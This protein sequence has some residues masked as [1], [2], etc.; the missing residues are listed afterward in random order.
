MN[1]IN[2]SVNSSLLKNGSDGLKKLITNTLEYGL[3]NEFNDKEL[4]NYVESFFAKNTLMPQIFFHSD[5]YSSVNFV[6]DTIEENVLKKEHELV[7]LDSSNHKSARIKI[8]YVKKND[9]NDFV[10]KISTNTSC[11]LLE[12]VDKDLNQLEFDF[13]EK[14]YE[15]CGQ[16]NIKLIINETYFQMFSTESIFL[17]K[18][19]NIKPD[20]LI[21]SNSLSG[22]L[23]LSTTL[24]KENIETESKTNISNISLCFLTET[25]KQCKKVDF[26]ELNQLTMYFFNS[27]NEEKE[28]YKFIKNIR[29]FGRIFAIDIIDGEDAEALHSC[30]FENG[31]M[32]TLNQKNS[33]IVNIPIFATLQE[34]NKIAKCIKDAFFAFSRSK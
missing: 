24:A 27:I 28:N 3:E 5:K 14:I 22:N 7:C 13:V 31:I 16:N 26:S 11:V 20:F 34:V 15:I 19:Y 10:E 1:K 21:L 23:P 4:L 18:K 29:T 25:I 32:T 8:K 30:F 6:I 2:C 12:L 33:I 9:I 17:Y